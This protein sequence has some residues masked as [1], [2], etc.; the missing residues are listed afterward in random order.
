MPIVITTE[1]GVQ[2]ETTLGQYLTDQAIPDLIQ[3]IQAAEHNS[4]LAEQLGLPP[5]ATVEQINGEIQR[6]NEGGEPLPGS[7]AAYINFT[8]DAVN[9]IFNRIDAPKDNVAALQ[10]LA[11]DPRA[12]EETVVIDGEEMTV[13]DWINNHL[14]PMAEQGLINWGTTR[15]PEELRPG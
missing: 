9:T 15:A 3:R 14:V 13:A 8:N 11:N 4:D 6:L 12:S 10:E 1:D 5:D 2:R 7:D